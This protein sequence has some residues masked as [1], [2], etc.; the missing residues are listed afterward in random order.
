MVSNDKKEFLSEF[1][2]SG[3]STNGYLVCK[4][5]NGYYQLQEG[6]SA[7]DFDYCECGGLLSYYADINEFHEFPEAVSA[8]DN[9][10]L[11]DDDDEI[12]KVL[13]NLKNKA[14]KRKK[15]FEELSQKLKIQEKLLDDIKKAKWYLWEDMDGKNSEEDIHVQKKLLQDII[16]HEKTY[17][18]D[19][20]VLVDN[21]IAE[22]SK[23]I[24][25]IQNKRESLTGSKTLK[26]KMPNHTE[27]QLQ[28]ADSLIFKPNLYFL[29]I[30]LMIMGFLYLFFM[31]I[32]T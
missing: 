24:S 11:A 17:L 31:L 28:G 21:I 18:Y 5:C 20:E 8:E 15:L 1:Y 9:I 13:I 23:F 29:I 4:E 7:S 27:G 26:D 25:I 3:I 32:L 16:D 10:Y 22:E 30:F 6:E 19:E 14:E 12:N 2:T